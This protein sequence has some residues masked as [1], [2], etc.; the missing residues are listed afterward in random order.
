MSFMD[1]LTKKTPKTQRQIPREKFSLAVQ[2][3]IRCKKGNW[4][5]AEE[6]QNKTK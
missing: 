2:K 3:K 6:G 1:H 5:E 4:M